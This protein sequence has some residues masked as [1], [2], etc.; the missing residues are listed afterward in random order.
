MDSI[1]TG[2][3][4]DAQSLLAFYERNRLSFVRIFSARFKRIFQYNNINI[5]TFFLTSSFAPADQVS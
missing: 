5:D 1:L 3:A 4:N 2:Y